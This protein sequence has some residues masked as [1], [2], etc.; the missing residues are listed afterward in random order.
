MRDKSTLTRDELEVLEIALPAT[1]TYPR[2]LC[3]EV[4]TFTALHE[5]HKQKWW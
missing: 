2:P 3:S 4:L 5:K 1:V